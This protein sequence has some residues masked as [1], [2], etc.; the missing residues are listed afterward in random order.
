MKQN[1]SD[2]GKQDIDW[3]RHDYNVGEHDGFGILPGGC[4]PPDY[5]CEYPSYPYPYPGDCWEFPHDYGCEYPSYPYP[6]CE[7]ED[8][9]I[10]GF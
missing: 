3:E 9:F 5:G 1:H 7:Y 6:G 2:F 4:Y 8:P 10:C